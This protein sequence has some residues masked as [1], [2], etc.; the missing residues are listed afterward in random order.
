V[1]VCPIWKGRLPEGLFALLSRECPSAHRHSAAL[2]GDLDVCS[3]G[4]WGLRSQRPRQFLATSCLDAGGWVT[5][6]PSSRPS[7]A[8]SRVISNTRSIASA[9]SFISGGITWLYTTLTGNPLDGRNVTSDFQI[10]LQRA[11]LPKIQFH[12]L[13]HSA[14]VL[15]LAEGVPEHEVG[16][17]PAAAGEVS[18][19][20]L[21]LLQASRDR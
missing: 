7:P 10:L 15:L 9:A 14:A 20:S 5:W 21:S 3:E 6:I 16:V 18:F 17:N 8:R 1:T 4:D 11:G 13:R 19:A 12:D 2:I